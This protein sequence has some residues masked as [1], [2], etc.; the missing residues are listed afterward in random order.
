M[1]ISIV[2]KPLG[3]S[4]ERYTAETLQQYAAMTTTT[5][6]GGSPPFVPVQVGHGEV[7]LRHA[8]RWQPL[9]VGAAICWD[10]VNT[11]ST[12]AARKAWN[13]GD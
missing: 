9:R 4:V 6:R 11:V 8:A 3:S 7:R 10:A 1:T 2:N 12:E 5:T 13:S